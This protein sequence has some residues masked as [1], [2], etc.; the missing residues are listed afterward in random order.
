MDSFFIYAHIY[1]L[2]NGFTHSSPNFMI[3][4]LCEC[5]SMASYMINKNISGKLYCS[6]LRAS[7]IDRNGKSTQENEF[8]VF[9]K[10]F[11]MVQFNLF[12]LLTFDLLELL[13]IYSLKLLSVWRSIIFRVFFFNCVLVSDFVFYLFF[14]NDKNSI[15]IWIVIVKVI[16]F[17]LFSVFF[18][19][20]GF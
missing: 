10:T 15:H 9:A 14:I 20:F 4:K 16:R 13:I 6:V 19:S 5:F 3:S 18:S 12:K 17:R 2:F 7:F 11:F 8:L 1:I